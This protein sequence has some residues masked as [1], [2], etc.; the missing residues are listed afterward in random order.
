[1]SGPKMDATLNA[2]DELAQNGPEMETT[3]NVEDNGKQEEGA[4]EKDS[5]V[6][7]GM[8]N[9]WK[10]EPSRRAKL[11]AFY[12]RR[13]QLAILSIFLQLVWLAGGCGYIWLSY[14][15]KASS[16]QIY[17]GI[18]SCLCFL[19]MYMTRGIVGQLFSKSAQKLFSDTG[20]A[21]YRSHCECLFFD[22][23]FDCY[24]AGRCCPS[25]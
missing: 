11:D 4:K 21:I 7:Q 13:C 17:F 8:A 5:L 6:D 16:W 10:L 25:N 14:N 12:K 18:V 23:F 15:S 1:M 22:D 19:S 24:I 9:Y 2:E 3:L 20:L